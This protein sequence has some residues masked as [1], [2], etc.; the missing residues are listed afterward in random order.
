[1][2]TG[3]RE[4][5]S[6]ERAVDGKLQKADIFSI[7]VAFNPNEIKAVDT[8]DEALIASLNKYGEVHLD[9]M[10]SLLPSKNR[11][12]IIHD[13]D[14]RIFYNPLVQNYEVRDR[15][16]AGNVVEKSELVERYVLNHPDDIRSQVSLKNTG[17][18]STA[19]QIR[20]IGF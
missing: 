11:D 3:G 17:C 16:I 19:D 7:P 15:F 2:D 5:L 8:S 12:E 10:D 18:Y 1:M 6:L 13:L 4:I 9:Y 14:G 20:R